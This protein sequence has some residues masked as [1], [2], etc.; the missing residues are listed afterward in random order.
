MRAFLRNAFAMDDGKPCEPAP[1]ERVVLEKLA[2][3]LARRR[4]SG[5]ALA[6]LEMSRPMNALGAA[7]LHFFSPLASTLAD[8]VALRRFAEF[9]DR[10]GSVD[11]L[12]RIIEAAERAHAAACCEG[13]TPKKP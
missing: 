1:E 13:E 7:A 4:M 12:C 8:P 2:D 10:R 3:E 5:P 11:V 6:F 9:L